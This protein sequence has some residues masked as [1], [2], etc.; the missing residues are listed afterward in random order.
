MVPNI[1]W[2]PGPTITKLNFLK[3]SWRMYTFTYL[4]LF[5]LKLEPTE[6]QDAA[7]KSNL[8]FSSPLA[9]KD[10]IFH[11]AVICGPELCK[12]DGIM[13]TRMA[14]NIDCYPLTL[15]LLFEQACFDGVDLILN[16]WNTYEDSGSGFR[17]ISV[18]LAKGRFESKDCKNCFS[19]AAHKTWLKRCM[20]VIMG[21]FWFLWGKDYC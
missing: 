13:K 21:S 9:L 14:S 20:T 2:L 18:I 8:D 15:V 6:V 7:K 5:T 19:S 1:V 12:R 4:T 17:V 10:W 16:Y 3:S 11:S